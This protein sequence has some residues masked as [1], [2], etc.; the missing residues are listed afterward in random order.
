MNF[1]WFPSL[2][3]AQDSSQ[4][5]SLLAGP[6]QEAEGRWV[7]PC[8]QS[9]LEVPPV[10]EVGR[11]SVH[12]LPISAKPCSTILLPQKCW[13]GAGESPWERKKMRKKHKRREK[14]WFSPL[15]D[16]CDV[17]VSSL[18]PWSCFALQS[19][20]APCPVLSFF[21]Q[22]Y[23]HHCH[24][25]CTGQR[26]GESLLWGDTTGWGKRQEGVV[27]SGRDRD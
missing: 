1:W 8:P 17:Q 23:G 26:E 3:S 15:V 12:P 27:F 21:H 11:A 10:L 9:N 20:I 19:Q 16:S 24:V 5:A 18:A 6:I 14:N 4:A 2:V 25:P 7:L 22:C 13:P